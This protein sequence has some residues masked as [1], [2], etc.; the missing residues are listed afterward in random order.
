M[1]KLGAQFK[2]ATG[3]AKE[4]IGQKITNLVGSLGNNAKSP[5]ANSDSGAGGSD[6]GKSGPSANSNGGTATGNG[7]GNSGKT[8]DPCGGQDSCAVGGV[9]TV[10]VRTPEK[11]M[12][13]SLDQEN[14]S[15]ATTGCFGGGQICFGTATIG[16]VASKTIPQQV[17]HF[18][19]NK[20]SK[21]TAA[22][23]KIAE[24]YGLNLDEAWNKDLLAHQGRHPNAYHDFVLDT[25]QTI[26]QAAAGSQSKFLELF[27]TYIKEPIRQAPEMLRKEWWEK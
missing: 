8:P 5:S 7:T 6:A 20:S 21:Y 27:N 3:E 19:T 17:H 2:A 23:S 11:Q 16:S 1:E 4:A 15:F 24:K 13:N 10:V 22:L 14:R 25:M 9:Q 26:D 18:A 12:M